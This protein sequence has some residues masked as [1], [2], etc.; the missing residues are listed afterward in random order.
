M[1]SEI[2][3]P[4]VWNSMASRPP[5]SVAK[6]K[7]TVARYGGALLLS[8]GTLLAVGIIACP[9]L[10]VGSVTQ[11]PLA[12]VGHPA[13]A[14]IT[15]PFLAVG[16]ALLA[17]VASVVLVLPTIG[18]AGCIGRCVGGRDAWWWTPPTAIAMSSVPVLGIATL[19]GGDTFTVMRVWLATSALITVVSLIARPV[20]VRGTTLSL[21]RAVGRLAGWSTAAVTVAVLAGAVILVSAGPYRAPELTRAELVGSWSDGDGGRLVLR[22]DG[23]ATTDGLVSHDANGRTTQ[24]SSRGVWSIAEEQQSSGRRVSVSIT[25]CTLGTE[26]EIGGEQDRPT[27]Y[28]FIGDPDSYEIY[29]LRRTAGG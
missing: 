8:L 12:A 23:T 2:T 26:W 18:L 24:C 13:L 7:S 11:E 10:V 28:R 25:E 20:A 6:E 14:L 27:L 3:P 15:L 9:A 19:V 4:Q 29:A 1:R 17:C 21:G 22:A 16:G 5:Y